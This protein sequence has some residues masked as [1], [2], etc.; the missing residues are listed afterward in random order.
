[1]GEEASAEKNDQF[2]K[3]EERMNHILNVDDGIKTTYSELRNFYSIIGN[4][5][6]GAIAKRLSRLMME[7]MNFHN[8]YING[9]TPRKDEILASIEKKF[10]DLL[11]NIPDIN[12]QNTQAIF[13]F[14]REIL[15]AFMQLKAHSAK[16]I[17]REKKPKKI[18][19]LESRL[20]IADYLV[21]DV[22]TIHSALLHYAYFDQYALVLIRSKVNKDNIKDL[23]KDIQTIIKQSFKTS[24]NEILDIRNLRVIS[25]MTLRIRIRLGVY[26]SCQLFSTYNKILKRLPRQLVQQFNTR[27]FA[28]RRDTAKD[29]DQLK[30]SDEYK[31]MT[32]KFIT[33]KL[34]KFYNLMRL[35]QINVNRLFIIEDRIQ[36]GFSN[37]IEKIEGVIP[38]NEKTALLDALQESLND[39]VAK[40][41]Q[42]S[43]GLPRNEDL[44]K[45]S[46]K[47]LFSFI[48]SFYSNVLKD[49]YT[50]DSCRDIAIRAM[51][52]TTPPK[53][54]MLNSQELALLESELFKRDEKVLNPFFQGIVSLVAGEEEEQAVVEP[55]MAALEVDYKRGKKRDMRDQTVDQFAAALGPTELALLE[56]I[57]NV[58]PHD[59]ER[60]SSKLGKIYQEAIEKYPTLVKKK[61]NQLERIEPTDSEK[62]KRRKSVTDKYYR[63]LLKSLEYHTDRPSTA[64][65]LKKAQDE[66]VANSKAEK[67]LEEMH[68][69]YN[70]SYLI[71]HWKSET[72]KSIIGLCL[73]TGEM[74]QPPGKFRDFGRSEV[75]KMKGY[76]NSEHLGEVEKHYKTLVE[77]IGPDYLKVPKP[78]S[79]IE[80]MI[81]YSAKQLIVELRNPAKSYPRIHERLSAIS[82]KK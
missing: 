48:I 58:V 69:I 61:V 28:L 24:K 30:D 67:D 71:S 33:L 44:K 43:A 50:P 14:L 52:L 36:K 64:E 35:Y 56:E 49:T 32:K 47:T 3:V 18:K 40:Y 37:F 81:L 70:I 75:S 42:I 60:V 16:A 82:G 13:Q 2:S 57:L 34:K 1:M 46:I 80:Y 63:L 76:F 62:E 41:L 77:N 25:L 51:K 54:Q 68:S 39:G 38:I 26:E 59:R 23:I 45:N 74:S 4:D 78:Y 79:K 22:Y 53:E 73:G 72:D 12:P 55:L 10:N 8:T 21:R 65:F 6:K 5:I 19:Q 17:K 7:V 31:G 27:Y 29:I 20:H 15:P 11:N 66:E 9:K